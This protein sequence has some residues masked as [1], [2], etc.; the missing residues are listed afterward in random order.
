VAAKH[1]VIQSTM[2]KITVLIFCILVILYFFIARIYWQKEVFHREMELLSLASAFE[3]HIQANYETLL[4]YKEDNIISEEE[5]TTLTESVFQDFLNTTA[6]HYPNV[7]L[8]YYDLSLKST[9]ASIPN[10]SKIFFEAISLENI[11]RKLTETRSPEFLSDAE[12]IDWDGKGII[13]AAVPL[14]HHGDI[15]GFTWAVM[16]SGEI[17]YGSYVNYSKVFVPSIILW[18]FVLMLIKRNISAIKVSIDTFTDII[19]KNRLDKIEDLEKLPEL[20]PVYEQIRKHLDE[21]KELNI[22]LEDSNA[23]LLTIMEGISDGFFSLDRNWCFTFVNKETKRIIGQE[24]NDL[25]GQSIWEVLP[26]ALIPEC[27]DNLRLAMSQN[28]PLHWEAQFPNRRHYEI[29]TYPFVRGLS[30]FIRDITDSKLQEQE[31]IRLERLNLIGQMAAGISHEVRNPLTTV[32][33]FLQMLESRADSLQNK[34]YMEIMISEIDRANGI[35]T[36]FLSLAKANAECTKHENINEIISRI[37]PM[38]QADAFNSNKDVV[39]N[40]GEISDLEVNESEIRQLILN[41]VRNGLEETPEG[42]QVSISTYREDNNIVLAIQDEGK[43]IPQEVQEKMGTPF[44]TT[45]ETGTGLGLAI[46]IGIARRHKAKFEFQTGCD[47]TIFF[48]R[49]PEP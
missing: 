21:L 15:V 47:G 31:M 37:F 11:S 3:L 36:D 29:Q 20:I 5:R 16:D 27:S 45:K 42:G 41:L 38:L 30:V 32:R 17:F 34:E 40:L 13:G 14:F 1:S 10:N 39:L 48:I 7:M 24:K 46:S 2:V 6:A 49:F 25:V 26:E 28:T 8:G 12:V 9:V 33:G 19:V 22:R 35:I 18:I 4:K 44:I 23:K 43:G